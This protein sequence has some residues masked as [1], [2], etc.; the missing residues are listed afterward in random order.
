MV[1]E[2]K[3]G[4]IKTTDVVVDFGDQKVVERLADRIMAHEYFAVDPNTELTNAREE[5][6]MKAIKCRF[7]PDP[8]VLV[9]GADFQN[10]GETYLVIA[11]MVGV[12]DFGKRIIKLV[13]SSEQLRQLHQ[14]GGLKEYPELAETLRRKK[15]VLYLK[16]FD[17]VG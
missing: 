1:L 8:V 13:G 4:E 17:E 7:L 16:L 5:I 10:G 12:S 6:I 2:R 14:N 9:A 11:E 3:I 15:D